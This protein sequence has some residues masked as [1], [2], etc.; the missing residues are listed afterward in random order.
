MIHELEQAVSRT[1]ETRSVAAKALPSP[2][3]RARANSTVMNAR[4]SVAL[5]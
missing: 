1:P 2:N 3:T 5:W 4:A